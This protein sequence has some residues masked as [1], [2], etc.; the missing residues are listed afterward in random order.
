MGQNVSLTY[1]V[2]WVPWL[3]MARY[4]HV[5]ID[6]VCMGVV[7]APVRVPESL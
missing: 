5:M 1:W 6:I 2:P 3:K 4:D 7:E